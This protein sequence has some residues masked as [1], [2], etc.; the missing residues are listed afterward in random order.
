M[1]QDRHAPLF[2][3]AVN[4]FLFWEEG[5]DMTSFL[6]FVGWCEDETGKPG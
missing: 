6:V 4:S 2:N 5:K 3:T 1:V